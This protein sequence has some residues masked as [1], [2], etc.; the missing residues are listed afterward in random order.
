MRRRNREFLRT[1]DALSDMFL[2]ALSDP[3]LREEIERATAPERVGTIPRDKGGT[4]A[5][6]QVMSEQNHYTADR[7]ERYARVLRSQPLQ[8]ETLPLE[9]TLET[10]A[11]IFDAGLYFE[12]H[13]FL[14]RLWRIAAPAEKGFIKALIWA[15]VAMYHL[16]EGN[17]RGARNYAERTT[18]ALK[19][20][21]PHRHG[22]DVAGLIELL[23]CVRESLEEQGTA[24]AA[25][26]PL[27]RP[28]MMRLTRRPPGQR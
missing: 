14:E 20:Y 19:P 3:R 6:G 26:T 17:P 7:M 25:V 28:P 23:D 4:L 24:D 2:A 21:E 5:A 16:E 8:K 10:A 22:I 1:R 9:R 11:A 15:C 18:A 27:V 12:C 13:E